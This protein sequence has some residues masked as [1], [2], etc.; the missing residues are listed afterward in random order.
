MSLSV[1][2]RIA[3]RE[4]RAGLRDFRVFLLCLSL[5]IAAI[6]AVGS[7]R[8]GIEQGLREEGAVILGGDAEMEFTYRFAS[9]EERAWMATKA[10]TISEIVDFRSMLVRRS[11]EGADRGLTQ[12][13]AVDE[14]YPIYGQVRLTPDIGLAQAFEGDGSLPGVVIHESLA[15]QMGLAIGNSVALGAQD[16]IITALLLAEPDNATGGFGLGPRTLVATRDLAQSGLLAA[17]SLF[18]TQ[19]RLKLPEGADLA[20]LKTEA[21]GLFRDKG[22]RWSDRR[23]GAP[24]VDRFIE[25]IGSFLVLVGLAGLAVGGIGVSASV[26]AYLEKKTEVIAILKT[27]GADGRTIFWAYFLQIGVL[28]LVGIALGLALGA[29]IPW[30]M[31][32]VLSGQLPVPIRAGIHPWPLTE[33]A[34]YGGLTALI[35]TLWPI[36]RTRSI[37]PA[38]LFRDAL[39]QAGGWIPWSYFLAI[40]LSVAALFAAAVT[41]ASV[42]L[43]A[44]WTILGIGGALLILFVAALVV[45]RLARWLAA[46]PGL[47]GR[48]ALRAALAAIGGPGSEAIPAILSLGLG[49]TVLSAIGQIDYNLRNAISGEL[50]E[51]AP[52]FFFV[53][54][55]NNQLEGFLDLTKSSETVARVDT[56]PM[57]RGIVTKLNGAPIREVVGNHWVVSGDRGI[58][59]SAAPMENA[60]VVAGTWWPENYTGP[61]QISFAREEAEEMGLKMGDVLTINILGRDIDAAITS[62]RDVNFS[63][64]G[65]GF[66]I[67]M[68]PAAVAGAPHT[69][70]ATVYADSAQEMALLRKVGDAFPNVTAIRIRD[71]IEQVAGALTGLA[72][73]TAYAALATLATGF[74]VLIGTAAAGEQAR[75]YEAALMKTLG[76][77]RARILASFA[78]RA[79][80]MGTAA[81]VFAILAGGLAGWAVMTFVMEVEYLFEPISSLLI[82]LGGASATILAGL[83]FALRPLAARPAQILRSRE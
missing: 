21:R 63:N 61:P 20:A 31:S 73:A 40:L 43:L 71:A 83:I 5:G 37:R 82:V 33:A 44:V 45:R 77:T 72:A 12:V 56:A 64:A 7:V 3:R 62:F 80:L 4:L 42:P 19:Y 11:A 75:T 25:R 26:R 1:A 70:I 69:H 22:L 15:V 59:Y 36:S 68:N 32:S 2:V 55:Q 24:G 28:A 27:I 47:R 57:L 8:S 60:P 34:I 38:V 79:A 13:K 14:V 50:P 10:E 58:T 9:E 65:I 35:F 18:E 66:V 46:K 81:G 51:I 52:S 6:A 23:N 67:A 76:A 49:L 74:V 17:G 29:A 54:I 39:D 16:F 41:F 30:A 48:T 53:D 78:L